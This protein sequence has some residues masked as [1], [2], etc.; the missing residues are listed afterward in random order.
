MLTFAV[1]SLAVGAS[2]LVFQGEITP[3]LETLFKALKIPIH[4]S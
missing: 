4:S 1:F 3:T 2:L